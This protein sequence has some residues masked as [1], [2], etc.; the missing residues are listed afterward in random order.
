M[1]SSHAQTSAMKRRQPPFG[2]VSLDQGSTTDLNSG[3]SPGPNLFIG[4]AAA[5]SIAAAEL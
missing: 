1:N 2:I 5:N 3:Q 4:F